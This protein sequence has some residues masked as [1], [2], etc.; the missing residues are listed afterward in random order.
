M[1]ECAAASAARTGRSRGA[2]GHK[3][4]VGDDRRAGPTGESASTA[5]TLEIPHSHSQ[6]VG[7]GAPGKSDGNVRAEQGAA[8][9]RPTVGETRVARKSVVTLSMTTGI[10]I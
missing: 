4:A 3:D 8:Q 9:S 5:W 1:V 10:A 6:V 7:E 2:V